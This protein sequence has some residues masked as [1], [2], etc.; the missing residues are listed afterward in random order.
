MAFISIQSFYKN[1]QQEV[2]GKKAGCLT[3][4]L[5]FISIKSSIFL[6]YTHTHTHTLLDYSRALF[7]FVHV[8]R[9]LLPF[10]TDGPGPGKTKAVLS[11]LPSRQN[12]RPHHAARSPGPLL[13]PFRFSGTHAVWTWSTRWRPSTPCRPGL[14]HSR[15]AGRS[16]GRV[17]LSCAAWCTPRPGGARVYRSWSRSG[18]RSSS[19]P[20]SQR[21]AGMGHHRDL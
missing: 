2:A 7:L 21:N 4:Y 16:P 19:P 8:S 13:H 17:S 5:S 12:N 9:P 6:N 10:I 15:S 18:G 1:V 20:N 3:T 14:W 11:V